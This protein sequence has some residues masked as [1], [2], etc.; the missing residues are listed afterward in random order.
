MVIES[1][2]EVVCH[3]VEFV[4]GKAQK[5]LREKERI[6]HAAIDRMAELFHVSRDCPLRDGAEAP[7]PGQSAPPAVT[8]L[9]RQAAGKRLQLRFYEENA[10]VACDWCTILEFD[11]GWANVEFV[12]EKKGQRERRLIPLSSIRSIT[13]LPE[14]EG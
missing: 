9:L 1:Y 11:G 5:F 3:G 10:A 12:R 14:G 2:A 13:F 4:V 7:A 6:Y 8:R